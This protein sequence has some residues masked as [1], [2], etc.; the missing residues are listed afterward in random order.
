MKGRNY[1]WIRC[2][3]AYDFPVD[4]MIQNQTLKSTINTPFQQTAG[5]RDS[6]HKKQSAQTSTHCIRLAKKKMNLRI[7]TARLLEQLEGPREATPTRAYAAMPSLELNPGKKQKGLKEGRTWTRFTAAM[8]FVAVH[9]EATRAGGRGRAPPGLGRRAPPI[10]W[11]LRVASP[12]R[13]PPRAPGR[14]RG[15]GR[16]VA[17]AVEEDAGSRAA[18][19]VEVDLRG[20]GGMREREG[21]GVRPHRRKEAARRGSRE[22]RS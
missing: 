19:A 4:T 16:A 15:R 2:S 21:C 3:V 13:A 7:H 20:W 8:S 6:I 10:H 14:E 11:G 17:P 22:W 18:P 5:A 9:G 1:F 12:R